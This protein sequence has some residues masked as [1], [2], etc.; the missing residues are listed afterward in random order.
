MPF[1]ILGLGAIGSLLAF[2]L[3][4]VV[5]PNQVITLLHKSTG[6]AMVGRMQG[7]IV[8]VERDAFVS[9]ANGFDH[10]M[11]E[12]PFRNERR[13][14][15]KSAE[16]SDAPNI[17]TLFVT[18]KAHQT[19]GAISRLLPRLSRN[20]TIVLL[21]NG[22]GIHERLLEDV[23]RNPDQ[24]PHFILA[25]NTHGA[26]SKAPLRIVHTGVGEIQFG[27]V[28]QSREISYE[29]GFRESGGEEGRLS[30]L[31]PEDPTIAP[32][33]HS[34]RQ[35]V[36]AL[37]LMENLAVSWRP[38]SEIQ[39]ALRRKLAVNSVINP[40]TALMNCRNGDVFNSTASLRILTRV[41]SEAYAGF[42]AEM[43]SETQLWL[44]EQARQGADPETL[45]VGRV[46][47][48]LTPDALEAECLR[49]ADLTKGNVSS[50]LSDV[51][52]GRPTEIHFMNG[53][54]LRLGSRY[55]VEMPANAMLRNLIEMRSA[56]PLD[57]MF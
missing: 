28:P 31:V 33:Y 37:L 18:C 5:P 56:I 41:C 27:L 7:G 40:L 45:S 39:V 49:V 17:D 55:R 2:H 36:A 47:R 48:G 14:G 15:G 8:Q 23:F 20:S 52:R 30:D 19:V 9:S 34:L 50:M 26:F 53:H 51:R 54:L 13:S 11:F 46:P 44:D 10:E 43:Q 24:R 21:Q 22:M 57:Q 12:E 6:Q 42:A 32:R 16:R 35:T 38:I 29:S 25:T 4:R 1:H 3:R